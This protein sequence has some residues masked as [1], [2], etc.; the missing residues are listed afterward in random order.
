MGTRSAPFNVDRP[1]PGGLPI[2]LRPPRRRQSQP[3]PMNQGRGTPRRAAAQPSRVRAPGPPAFREP[4]ASSNGGMADRS[5]RLDAG[6]RGGPRVRQ[7][8]EE[9]SPAPSA[10]RGVRP[11]GGQF[12]RRHGRQRVIT[13]ALPLRA[14]GPSGFESS[15]ANRRGD[16]RRAPR[17]NARREAPCFGRR[18][19]SCEPKAS[20]FRR[21]AGRSA[22][23]RLGDSE[24][25]RGLEG[26]RSDPLS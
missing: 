15:H 6:P 21:G 10:G 1:Q 3:G 12:T 24:R 5:C 23:V 7:A 18:K 26:R 19:S 25:T 11:G 20:D 17:T 13:P 16:R 2:E 9:E 22:T 14:G 8:A 4:A